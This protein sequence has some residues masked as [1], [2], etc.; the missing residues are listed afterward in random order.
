MMGAV[1]KVCSTR[2]TEGAAL[3]KEEK[4][5]N[6]NVHNCHEK[7]YEIPSTC[8]SPFGMHRMSLLGSGQ[9]FGVGGRFCVVSEPFFGEKVGISRRNVVA[10]CVEVLCG[11]SP[12]A[13]RG[14]EIFCRTC[15]DRSNRNSEF[16]GN[17]KGFLRFWPPLVRCATHYAHRSGKALREILSF[18]KILSFSKRIFIMALPKWMQYSQESSKKPPG[19]TAVYASSAAK[20][21]VSLRNFPV[22]SQN[23]FYPRLA[24]KV[25]RPQ[26]C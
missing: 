3:R 22:C 9:D 13:A 17:F 26:S 4:E 18:R 15:E 11:E 20:Q 14:L 24:F 6:R 10:E 25:S 2:Q 8:T 23:Q 5:K 7:C 19:R 1:H 12:S 16:W 21:K